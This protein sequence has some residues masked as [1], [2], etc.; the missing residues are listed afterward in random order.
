[1]WFFLVFVLSSI[2]LCEYQLTKIS[3]LKYF[4][5]S[6]KV[7]STSINMNLVQLILL[8]YFHTFGTYQSTLCITNGEAWHISRAIDRQSFR[9]NY[10]HANIH[11]G[12]WGRTPRATGS[13]CCVLRESDEKQHQLAC[14]S[15]STPIAPVFRQIWKTQ[16][17]VDSSES[18]KV[19]P[20][21]KRKRRRVDE[22]LVTACTR[23]CQNGKF[24]C[25]RWRKFR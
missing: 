13:I 3:S 17:Y 2:F 6:Q 10:T 22:I 21:L 11:H 18:K 5:M 16:K 19:R 20:V 25:S 7:A 24:Q 4:W 14:S 12:G 1:M 8:S 15:G 23:R 9:I